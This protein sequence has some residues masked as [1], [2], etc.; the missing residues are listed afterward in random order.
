MRRLEKA[1]I[2]EVMVESSRQVHVRFVSTNRA[3]VQ[4]ERLK[5]GLFPVYQPTF[6][7]AH[8]SALFMPTVFTQ[9]QEVPPLFLSGL[10]P[11]FPLSQR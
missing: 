7:F 8:P 10:F 5:T 9:E 1:F 2:A 3:R 4:P 11:F 6:L